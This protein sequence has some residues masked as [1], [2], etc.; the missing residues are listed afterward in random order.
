MTID[1][2]IQRVRTEHN[3]LVNR[4]NAAVAE[5]NQL[6]G[7]HR[8]SEDDGRRV[9]ELRSQVASDGTKLAEL[10]EKLI[11]LEAE[12]L[13]DAAVERLQNETWTDYN[14]ARA[15]AL[16]AAEKRGQSAGDFTVP[17]SGFTVRESATYRKDNQREASYFRDLV[18]ARRGDLGASQ[19]LQRNEGE[20]RERH[21]L[22]ARALDTSASGGGSFAP[23]AWL[24]QD[25]MEMS[26]PARVTADLLHVEPLPGGVS[27]V[28]L[29]KVASG[30][31]VAVQQT[32][33]STFTQVDLTTT[34]V[35][36]GIVTI[37]GGQT[38]SMQLLNQSGTPIDQVV[39]ADLAADY[40]RAFNSQ[41]LTGTGLNGQL[42]GVLTVTA[43]TSVTYTS[44]TP[45][46]V[47]TT[48]ADSFYNAVLDA[49]LGIEATRFTSPDAIVMHPRRWNWI[50]K[51]LDGD[52]RPL[53]VPSTHTN[54]PGLSGA[55]VAAGLAGELAGL[56][57]YVDPLIPTNLGTG[58]NQDVVVL[59]KRDDLWLWESEL[60]LESFDQTLANQGSIYFRAVAFAALIADRVPASIAKISGT[61]LVTP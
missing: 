11:T 42:R 16:R 32:Q 41:V 58:T 60:R 14:A 52:G 15:E 5:K 12:K 51:A 3:G 6:E 38:V 31:S 57:V 9:D 27:S 19:R 7:K 59:V 61:G 55:P 13:R 28:N 53:V 30:S 47:S 46:V 4:Y 45:K 35:S 26:R 2:L 50:L 54:A 29:P 43:G 23:P 33:N 17:G 10:S 44:A 49:K 8:L 25:L 21:P 20:W 34:S 18:N 56:P 22:E 24:V 36:S 40:A 37:A 1:E 48:A 39:L